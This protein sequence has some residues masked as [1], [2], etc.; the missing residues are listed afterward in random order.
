MPPAKGIP[1]EAAL[2]YS[3]YAQR[4]AQARPELFQAALASIDEPFDADAMRACLARETPGD[5][6]ALKRTLRQLRQQVMLRVLLR[7]LSGRAPLAE[8]MASMSD[9]AELSLA[10]ALEYLGPWL[11]AQHGTP[12]AEGRRQELLVV[13]MGKL[14][15]RELN[16]SSDID[17]I[18][19]YPE[20]GDTALSAGAPSSGSAPRRLSNHEYFIRLGRRLINA[21]ADITED[22]QVFRVDMRL[23]PNGDS[24]PLVCSFD[25][26]ENYF[27]AEGREWERYAWIKARVVAASGEANAFAGSGATA[28]ANELARALGAVARPFVFRKYLDFGA[29]AAMRSL[30]AQI[31]A[32]VARRDL[33]GHVKLGPGGIREIEFI[34]QAFQLIRGGRDAD[35]QARP[36]LEVLALLQ[37]KG[38]LSAEAV[39]EL[40]AAYD[41]L[42]R[43]EHR[44]QYLDDAQT[45]DL[46]TGGDDQAL[47]A[48]AMGFDDYAEFMR[49][50]DAHRERV[51]RHFDDV[52]AAPAQDEHACAPLWN[53]K[54]NAHA[55]EGQLRT[56]GFA[57]AGDALARLA[58]ARASPRYAQLPETS[59]ERYDAL[60]PRVIELAAMAGAPEAALARTLDLLEAISRR[61]SYLAL[62]YEYPQ[63]LE[64]VVQLLSASGW[65]AA[66][67]TRHPLLLDELL[68]ARTL[69]AA[70][71]WKEFAAYLRALLARHEGDAE[72]Q[73]DV[74][75]EAHHA[76]VF[77]LLAQDLAGQ[78][79]VEVLADHLSALA[80]LMLTITL[81]LCWAQ[82]RNRHR[83]APRF[84]VIAYGKLGGKELGYASDLD[85]IF[86]YQDDDARAP[87]LYARLAQR[88]NSWL[89]STTASGV[90]FETDLRL[91]PNGEGGLMVS[92]VDAF[93]EYQEK[94]AWVWEHQALTRARYCAGDAAVG[95]A[96]EAERIAILRRR[97]DPETLRREVV[98]M[99]ARMLDA[100]PNESG[101]F[102]LKHDRGGMIDIEF[103]VQY[104]VLAHAH[105]YPQ[106]TGNL[107]NIA[108]LKIAGELGLIPLA[109]AITVRDGYREYRRLQHAQRL[110]GAQYARVEQ[111]PLRAYIEAALKLWD[112]VFA[113]S[114]RAPAQS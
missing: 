12:T 89:T 10:Y 41:F 44:L 55:A 107:G 19:V 22:G 114:S 54:L 73:M 88:L 38:L 18:F 67:V 15:G 94:D 13:G 110:N 26:L 29:F 5:E 83:E 35:L 48:A 51:S 68:D 109:T 21:L 103:I 3:R 112:I 40:H 46:P 50:L 39:A 30:H 43:V 80:D 76:Q 98:A 11:E 33:V 31:R 27:I 17:L 14:G 108:L 87:Q 66:Y 105:R 32:E 36:T 42:R 79:T 65:A 74:L 7:D 57:D 60:L 97:R 86:L 47:V 75:R 84:A 71:D 96:F 53:G 63:A 101:L 72:R 1:L 23:R 4:L 99:R 61:S 6:D 111:E 70:P 20:E 24:G 2:T 91:R 58:A 8:V 102:D 90:L 56:L 104:L 92:S 52:F 49:R 37:K 78:L 113:A 95:A 93:R 45:H 106:L 69:Y 85:I 77:R 82:L 16:V 62:L 64:K 81:E 25:A 34:A 100:H 59:R 9:L 28:K